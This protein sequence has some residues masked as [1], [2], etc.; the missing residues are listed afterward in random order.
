MNAFQFSCKRKK[1]SG[2]K[3]VSEGEVVFSS[4]P[5]FLLRDDLILVSLLNT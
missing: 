4:P 1:N 2:S 5:V 3:I